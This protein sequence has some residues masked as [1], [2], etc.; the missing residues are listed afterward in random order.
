MKK[1]ILRVLCAAILISAAGC[2]SESRRERPPRRILSL[3][4]AAT[5]TLIALDAAPAAVDLYGSEVPGAE[6]IPVAGKGSALSRE[7]LAELGIDGAIV[8]YY[9]QDVRRQLES[10]GIRVLT[11][12][13]MRLREIPAWIVRAGEFCGRKEAA[14]AL[15]AEFS[16]RISEITVAEPGKT[17]YVYWELYAPGK[18]A[19]EE[20]YAGDLLKAAG[21]RSVIRK[22]GVVSGEFLAER[23]PDVILY[24]EGFGTAAEIARRP[25]LQHSP[26]AENNRIYAVPRRLLMEG[27]APLEAIAF[28]KEKI[29]GK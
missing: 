23:P 9:Q 1:T 11:A 10:L 17:V 26:A 18:A 7:I 4:A 24:V 12:P 14:E 16:R 5:G 3:S 6:T 13:P 20:S 15:S 8:W 28:I 2:G 22:T 29:A 19:G 25:E 27:V 21:C